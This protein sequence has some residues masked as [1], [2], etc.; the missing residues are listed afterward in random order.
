MSK[1]QQILLTRQQVADLAHVTV[2]TINAQMQTGSLKS[3][4]LGKP[5]TDCVRD[6]RPVR[7][8]IGDVAEFSRC[9]RQGRKGSSRR[10]R[11]LDSISPPNMVGCFW[12]IREVGRD[13]NRRSSKPVVH[14]V[15]P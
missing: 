2:R 11:R 1:T 12:T 8:Y 9:H 6:N 4:K 7:L 5:K 3:I 10:T 15:L 14:P 13:A